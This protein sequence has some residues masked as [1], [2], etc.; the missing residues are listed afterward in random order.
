M[1]TY[2]REFVPSRESEADVGSY[3]EWIDSDLRAEAMERGLRLRRGRGVA[4]RFRRISALRADDR[5][6]A[7]R[8]AAA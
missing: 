3:D 8:V 7:Q 4:L 2:K 6:A 5:E 1:H